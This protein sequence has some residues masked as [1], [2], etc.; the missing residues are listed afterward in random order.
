LNK[1]K[2][3]K[4]LNGNGTTSSIIYGGSHNCKNFKEWLYKDATI[5]LKRKKDI[6]ESITPIRKE[7]FN[8]F[9]QIG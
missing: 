3:N 7:K 9:K 6:F 2:I 8:K 4:N 5:F 1:V